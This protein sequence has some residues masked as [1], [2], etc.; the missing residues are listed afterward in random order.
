MIF[1]RTLRTTRLCTGRTQP[2]G[3]VHYGRE[4]AIFVLLSEANSLPRQFTSF[5]PFGGCEVEVTNGD[6]RFQKMV[7]PGNYYSH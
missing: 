1:S 4:W 5:S 7:L 2:Q 3:K 6:Y